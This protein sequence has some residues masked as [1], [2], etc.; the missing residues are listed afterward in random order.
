A[1]RRRRVRGARPRRRRGVH[2]PRPAGRTRRPG[3]GPRRRP[4]TRG[5]PGRGPRRLTA[6]RPLIPDGLGVSAVSA[7]TASNGCRDERFGRGE[8][9]LP[10]FGGAPSRPL[11]G[12]LQGPLILSVSTAPGP[13]TCAGGRSQTGRWL[14]DRRG[15]ARG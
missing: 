1:A 12:A 7:G 3:G 4:G 8:P 13:R 2:R 15:V 11:R 10:P 14:Q 6:P 9:V 5:G